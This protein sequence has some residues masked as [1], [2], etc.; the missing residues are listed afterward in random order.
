MY[1]AT[2]TPCA[3]VFSTQWAAWRC[4][5]KIIPRVSPESRAFFQTFS[6][7]W[8]QGCAGRAGKG[9]LSTKRK[10]CGHWNCY[11]N[12]IAEKYAH[13]AARDRPAARSAAAPHFNSKWKS[14]VH[15][16][17]QATKPCRLP[18]TGALHPIRAEAAPKAGQ[19]TPGSCCRRAEEQRSCPKQCAP[20]PPPSS[21][22][23]MLGIQHWVTQVRRQQTQAWQLP[24]LSH[25]SQWAFLDFWQVS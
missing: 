8:Q 21:H 22:P 4:S 20:P 1:G 17:I 16:E 15:K 19:A 24:L 23:L 25:S 7:S 12:W 10:T 6:A 9:E 13:G 5:I 11:K 18:C 14:M 2:S 3:Q